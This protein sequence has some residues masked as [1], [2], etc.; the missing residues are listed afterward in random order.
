MNQFNNKIRNKIGN[1]IRNKH[2]IIN[3]ILYKYILLN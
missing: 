2:E 1:K 3:N